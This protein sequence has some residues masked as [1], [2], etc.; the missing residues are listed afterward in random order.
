MRGDKDAVRQASSI[1]LLSANITTRTL[2]SMLN[3]ATGN[4]VTFFSR[5][6]RATTR[7]GYVLERNACVSSSSISRAL[8][9]DTG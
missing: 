4:Q 5:E 7:R 1:T 6:S 8:L 3:V 2:T 9:V